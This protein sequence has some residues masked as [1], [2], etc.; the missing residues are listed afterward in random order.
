MFLAIPRV[1]GG[2]SLGVLL[3]M[4]GCGDCPVGSRLLIHGQ[5]H[6]C[7]NKQKQRHGPYSRLDS[8]GNVVEVGQYQNGKKHGH[9]KVFHPD[10]SLQMESD[11]KFHQPT[12]WTTLYKNG[13][14]W[15]RKYVE[16][17]VRPK[18]QFSYHT[19]GPKA[20]QFRVA[21]C[22][23]QEIK[24]ESIAKNLCMAEVKLGKCDS[25]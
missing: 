7:R 18:F 19:S 3:L 25:N 23:G 16:G 20:G 10:G 5:E 21:R 4:I 22:C 24:K 12:G 1:L 13:H 8:K 2:V 9:W 17:S 11:W 15:I 14:V 6:Y